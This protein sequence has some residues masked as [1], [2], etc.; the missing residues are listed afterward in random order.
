MPTP[1]KPVEIVAA[2]MSMATTSCIFNP[3][4]VVKCRIQAQA[5]LTND[6]SKRIYNGTRDA[7]R[8]IIAEEGL[9]GVW[10][11]GL[12]ASILRDVCNGAIRMGMYPFVR[13]ML[14]MEGNGVTV[15]L[16]AGFLTGAFG[17]LVSNPADLTKIRFQTESGMIKDGVYVTGMYAGNK[18]SYPH[19]G[20]AIVGLVQKGEVFRGV[21]T[22]MARAALVT[23]GQVGSYDHTKQ[24]LGPIIGE[25]PVL[26][27]FAGAVSGF[28]ATTLAAPADLIKTRVM[29]DRAGMNMAGQGE[30]TLFGGGLDCMARTFSHEGM[31]GFFKGWLAAYM[32]LGPV[33]I[34]SWPLLELIR[35]Q[36]FG[37][38]YFGKK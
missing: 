31:R 15:K 13:D 5:S 1:P 33:F 37:L 24:T 14:P 29:N 30:R 19:T 20:A 6:P 28:A 7:F 3:L 21:G 2:S 22:S 17:A 4:D 25:G 18:P 38:D 32:R 8:K 9:R 27:I 35:T 11:P 23:A 16:C 10:L 34:V 12:Q 26:F 36:V